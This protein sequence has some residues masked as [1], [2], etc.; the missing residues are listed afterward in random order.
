MSLS[1]GSVAVLP[2]DQRAAFVER[3]GGDE[4]AT[5]IASLADARSRCALAVTPARVAWAMAY[6]VTVDHVSAPGTL[7]AR[8][9][10][11]TTAEERWTA[12]TPWSAVW[13]FYTQPHNTTVFAGDE[14]RPHGRTLLRELARSVA[15][16]QRADYPWSAAACDPAL[17]Q[18]CQNEVYELSRTR[19]S[20]VIARRVQ[21][22]DARDEI[23]SETWLRAMQSAWGPEAKRR[24]V[25][26][27]LL[28]SWL[29]AVALNT[30]RNYTRAYA[31]QRAR[32]EPW[33]EPYANRLLA[34]SPVESRLDATH[35]V[36]LSVRFRECIERLPERDR[37][38]L[39]YFLDGVPPVEIAK[40]RGT[41]PPTI[42]QHQERLIRE[43]RRCFADR[44]VRSGTSRQKVFKS[45]RDL[46]ASIGPELFPFLKRSE[47]VEE[48]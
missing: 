16:E 33:T 22:V 48:P 45:V 26:R 40:V 43:L 41:S 28:S 10:G 12:A 15:C 35:E 1:L 18:D 6:N 29:C 42:S 39:S 38:L 11:S 20:G 8:F 32:E 17:A 36:D 31:R 27:S 5:A 47:R 14:Q 2:L 13:Q 34:D 30:A 23:I 7:S 37:E 19:V 24:F 4:L 44:S 46:L 25:G 9:V 3:F 21:W